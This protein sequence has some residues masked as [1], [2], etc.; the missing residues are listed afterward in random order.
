MR[1]LSSTVPN[2]RL[3]DRFTVIGDL[4][5][6]EAPLYLDGE[7]DVANIL[8]IYRIECFN[9]SVCGSGSVANGN[10]SVLLWYYVLVTHELPC[11]IM[12]YTGGVHM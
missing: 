10:D 3:I 12:V 7:Y 4:S 8:L 5:S 1:E 6:G 11:D 9:F 2:S